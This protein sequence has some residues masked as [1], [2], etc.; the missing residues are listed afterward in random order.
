M[1]PVII[2][3][4]ASV[5]IILVSMLYIVYAMYT[6]R[7]TPPPKTIDHFDDMNQPKSVQPSE[8]VSDPEYKI[9]EIEHFLTDEECDHIIAISKSELTPSKVYSNTTDV[10]D[11]KTR[12][13]DQAW[14][15]DTMD[16]VIASISEKV[17]SISQIPIEHQEDLQVVSYSPGGFFTPHYDACDGDEEFCK[18]MDG[19]S[20]PRLFT[21]L[22][23]L[24]DDYEGG[25]T[26]FPKLNITVT[27]KKGK[28]V[29]FQNTLPQSGGK[30]PLEALHGGNPVKSGN[31]WICN[32][33]IRVNPFVSSS[34]SS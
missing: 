23:Y 5:V 32:K 9:R 27:P 15:K 2:I 31:K 14:L 21:Y 6:S 30:I 13:S 1:N 28:C 3:Y 11:T 24:N 17:A 12:K 16:P 4:I 29:I 34:S 8:K 26:V 33:W 7:P 22:I 18:R 20:G 10:Y 19:A 25:E